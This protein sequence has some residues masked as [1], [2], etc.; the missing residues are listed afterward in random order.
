MAGEHLNAPAKANSVL[1]LEAPPL[2]HVPT[3]E[4]ASIA[5]TIEQEAGI[6]AYTQVSGPIDLSVVEDEFR[7]IERQTAQYI[8]GSIGIPDYSDEH[9]PHVYVHTD[10]W[11]LAYY[12]AAEP[13]AYIMD[14]VHYDG[15]EMGTTKLEDAMHKVLLSVG[16]VSFETSYYNFRYPNAT[17]IMLIAEA[18][19]DEGAE[20]FDVYLPDELTYYDRS[21]LH[22]LYVEHY[23]DSSGL[24]LDGVPISFFDPAREDESDWMFAREYLT[25]AQLPPE[26]EHTVAVQLEEVY[27]SAEAFAGLAL[28]YRE[29]P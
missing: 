2:A 24:T 28:V 25:T 17:H 1:A 21:W 6:A 8:I 19:H 7:A 15:V 11:V 13:A 22:A 14:P 10:G 27:A 26:V 9:D 16:I 23:N 4:A 3:G 18:I 5:S 29:V 12:L 20:S